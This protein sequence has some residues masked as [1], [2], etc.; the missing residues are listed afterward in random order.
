MSNSSNYKIAIVGLGYV[1]LPLAHAFSEKFNVIGFDINDNRIAELSS[2]QDS[3][4][5]LSEMQ[6]QEY[7]D[8]GGEVCSDPSFLADCNVYIVTVPTPIDSNKKPDLSAL[9]EA[10]ISI[11]RVLSAGNIVIYESTVY[12][13]ATEEECV[14]ILEKTSGLTFNQDFF[15]G[16]SPERINPGD[17]VHTVKKIKKIT[18]GSTVKIGKIVDSLYA[19]II[20]A[21]TFLA[22]SIKVA[23]A[24]KVIENA[25]RDINIAF[26]NELAIMFEKMDIN[27]KDVLEAAETKWN[28][29][30]FKP[31]L[32]GGHCIGVDPYYLAYKAQLLGYNPQMILSGRQINDG[33]SSHIASQ[34][35]KL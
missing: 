2:Y 33:M 9:I 31:G 14:P 28:F 13:G 10:S 35:I 4:Q 12:P 32:V 11:G 8:N 3:T 1:G 19:Q 7:F 17:K 29:L 5:E 27:T 16:Y 21:G 26:V 25:Q 15:C 24:A 34:L 23:E 6:L 22:P 20:D 30:P 18:S